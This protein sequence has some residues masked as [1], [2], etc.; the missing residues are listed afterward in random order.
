MSDG[1]GHRARK[2]ARRGRA[3]AEEN[4]VSQTKY[5][6]SLD[7]KF[8]LGKVL[9]LPQRRAGRASH[10][11]HAEGARPARRARIRRASFP[12][13][14]ARR[15]AGSTFSLRARGS[16]S[17]PTTSSSSR[18][19]TRSSRPPPAGARSKRRCA[20]RAA[21]TASSA[22]G[23]GKGPASIAP[24]TRCATPISPAPRD[25]AACSRSW[26]TITRPNPRPPR[27]RASSISST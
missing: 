17:R 23:T 15:S 22:S 16:C 3:A 6:V 26:A 20:A 12:A 25:M 13:I 1:G 19:S 24:A 2:S 10:A 27:I 18:A 8:D 14:A 21:M 4:V 7:D 5:H 9:R 11:P